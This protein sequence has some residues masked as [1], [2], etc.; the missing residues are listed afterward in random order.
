MHCCCE[1]FPSSSLL[2]GPRVSRRFKNNFRFECALEINIKA[3][4]SNRLRATIKI[5]TRNIIFFLHGPPPQR[6]TLF[7]NRLMNYTTAENFPRVPFK[8]RLRWNVFPSL[9]RSRFGN[10]FAPKTCDSSSFCYRNNI[11]KYTA[12][13]KKIKKIHTLDKF[14]FFLNL[15]PTKFIKKIIRLYKIKFS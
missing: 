9:M 2:F 4:Y 15:P 7:V 11:S 13:S 14:N 1:F 12:A 3:Y 8:E 6:R 5:H 10:F